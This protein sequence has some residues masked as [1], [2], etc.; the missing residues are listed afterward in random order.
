MSITISGLIATIL[1]L[2]FQPDETQAILQLIDSALVVA[3]ILLAYLGRYRHGDI[4]WYGA[5][6]E[7]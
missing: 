7:L 5:K 6:R 4:T 3:G 2:V 1:G